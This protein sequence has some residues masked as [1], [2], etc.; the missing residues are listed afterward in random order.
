MGPQ[1]VVVARRGHGDAQ[2]VLVFVHTLDDSGQNQQKGQV[3]PGPGSGVQQIFP[4]VGG[5][6]P[7]VVLAAAVYTREG[8]LVEQAHQAVAV[9]HIAHDLHGQLVVVAGDVGGGEDGG[10]LMLGGGDLVVLGFGQH[11]QLPQLPVQVPHKSGHPGLDGPI[12]VVVHLLALGG[13][14]SKKGAAA[15]DQVPALLVELLVNEEI[16]LLG[17][18][19]GDHLLGLL[20]AQQAQ[21]PEGLV[22]QGLH[23]AQQRGLLV[24]HLAAVGAE[25]GG[26]VQGAPL[27]KGIGGRVPGG[28]APGLKGSPQAA[29]GERRGVRLALDELLAGKLHNHPAIAGGGDEAV[30]LFGGN[31][32]ERLKPVGIV[33]GA[34]LHGPVLHG[35]GHGV[36]HGQVQL[37]ALVDGFAQGAVHVLGQALHHHVVVEDG[38]AEELGNRL[39]V[40][41]TGAHRDH[42]FHIYIVYK[43]DTGKAGV[44]YLLLT[45]FKRGDA[46]FEPG[47]A[48]LPAPGVS[49]MESFSC[50][51]RRP[52]ENQ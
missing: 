2:Q 30:V 40:F 11:P 21:Q 26:D 23:R 3:L 18:H 50:S 51:P 45:Q 48:G 25:G 43:A 42:S 1:P 20:I 16:F 14:G 33:G 36:G 38:A 27:D 46:F 34:Q 9:R 32:V 22:A 37:L 15:E 49:V 31:A 5:K 41:G 24:Q 17:P 29:R 47:G 6:G 19:G 4:R 12:V 7:V 44:R 10:Q 35:G 13:L 8:L 52:V 39:A 28:V